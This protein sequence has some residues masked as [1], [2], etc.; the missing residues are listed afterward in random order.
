MSCQHCR[1]AI[2]EA[3]FAVAGVQAV[4]ADLERKLVE[5]EGVGLS[6]PQLRAALV[7]AGYEAD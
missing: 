6:D 4:R 7:E 3:L 2:G 5:V 1:A